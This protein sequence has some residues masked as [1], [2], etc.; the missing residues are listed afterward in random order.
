MIIVGGKRHNIKDYIIKE[1][2]NNSKSE[3]KLENL[4]NSIKKNYFKEL[5]KTKYNTGFFRDLNRLL[6]DGDV[7]IT[8][9][10]QPKTKT[11]STELK[12]SFNFG[13]LLIKYSNRLTRPDIYN[14]LNLM[15]IENECYQ[16][17]RGL[18]KDKLEDLEKFH[19]KRWSYLKEGTFVVTSNEI[20]DIAS[21]FGFYQ[22]IED[23]ISD[24]TEEQKKEFLEYWYGDSNRANQDL[25]Y[26]VSSAIEGI[27]EDARLR[28]EEKEQREH[29]KMHDELYYELEEDEEDDLEY[30]TWEEDFYDMYKV[31]EIIKDMSLILILINKYERKWSKIWIYPVYPFHFNDIWFEMPYK[32]GQMLTTDFFINAR[33]LKLDEFGIW[34]KESALKYEGYK[35][36]EKIKDYD[37]HFEQII[38]I[39]STYPE[40]QKTILMG[41]LAKGLSDEPGSI[42]VFAEFFEKVSSVRYPS[43]L[44]NVLGIISEY[45]DTVSYDDFK[46]LQ[47][48]KDDDF[49]KLQQ[50][51]D[52]DI[53]RLQIF[54]R[55]IYTQIKDK[56]KLEHLH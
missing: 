9:Y 11:K 32:T 40:E 12:Q 7:E 2:E 14:Y 10:S 5:D 4:K 56:E 55:D 25:V 19:S 41:I 47:Q 22:G 54:L 13:S 50:E 39:I 44:N 49:K 20:I 31:E 26:E 27:I 6:E 23:M 3:F 33:N 29:E 24:L 48:E 16:K 8:G 37:F 17:I 21:C 45:T 42:Q 1:L 51:K 30:E 28:K 52:E 18:F 35:K 36:P 15:F 53:K 34:D 43:R 46:K 38:D